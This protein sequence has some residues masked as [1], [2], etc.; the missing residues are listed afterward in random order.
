MKVLKLQGK[1]TFRYTFSTSASISHSAK[2][3]YCYFYLVCAFFCYLTLHVIYTL[4]LSSCVFFKLHVARKL[5]IKYSI[6][7]ELHLTQTLRYLSPA[8]FALPTVLISMN[9]C[10]A[11]FTA[12]MT[13]HHTWSFFAVSTLYVAR[14]YAIVLLLLCL[15]YMWLAP[16]HDSRESPKKIR[17]NI[18][19]L[20]ITQQWG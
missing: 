7:N 4:L 18:S 19:V 6:V 12:H 2:L 10:Y 11:A 14:I 20:V 1:F 9:P 17:F 15:D 16:H 3:F 5:P 13:L 8:A